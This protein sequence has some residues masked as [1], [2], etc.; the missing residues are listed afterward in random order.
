MV[1]REGKSVTDG[2]WRR[3]LWVCVAGSFTTLIGMTLLIPFLPIY[4]EQLGARGQLEIAWWSAT[5]YASTFLAAA[6]VAPLWGRLGDRYGRKQSLIRASLGMALAIS[7]TG[8][9]QNVF[10]LVALRALTGLLGGYA[11]GAT[12]LIAVG[13]PRDRSAWALGVL[14]SGT[15]AGSLVGP[16]VGGLLPPLIGIRGAFLLSGGLIF[17]AFVAT[18]LLVVEDRSTMRPAMSGGGNAIPL[19]HWL[20]V[21]ILLV[22]MLLT[23]ANFSIEPVLTIFVRSLVPAGSAVTVI[24]GVVMASGAM[25][26][27]IAAPRVGRLADRI[28]QRG[29]ISVGL[30]LAAVLLL[31]QA[32]VTAA[33]QLIMLRFLLGA[34]LGGMLPVMASWIRSTV[35]EGQLGK[36]LGLSTSA[37]Y[38]GQVAGPMTGGLVGGLVGPRAV[39]VMT[40]AVML[41]GAAVAATSRI[42]R[43]G[44]A[45]S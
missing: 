16:L 21:R 40:A 32:L 33:W 10:Q 12:I 39:F 30:G 9:A 2:G 23:F 26:S 35:P 42:R 25:G 28:G 11:S 3:N 45:A 4:V 6:L 44:V 17:C 19:D 24:A 14:A 29:V 15:M 7:L 38:V 1:K 20:V 8:L 27:I 31:A 34:S 36:M 5:A 43:A 37:Q 41:V 22:G 13:S 18:A